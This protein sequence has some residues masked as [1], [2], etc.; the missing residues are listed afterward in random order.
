MHCRRAWASLPCEAPRLLTT[1]AHGACLPQQRMEPSGC[2]S[3]RA[4]PCP[5]RA[6][7]CSTACTPLAHKEVPLRQRVKC[8]TGA[9]AG[10]AIGAGVLMRTAW[11]Q[12]VCERQLSVLF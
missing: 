4:G 10:R 11:T 7:L 1:A 12:G 6:L 2:S 8:I 9:F 3:E 5:V